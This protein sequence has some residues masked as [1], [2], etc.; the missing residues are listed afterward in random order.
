MIKAKKPTPTNGEL[1]LKCGIIRKS[2][3]A[4]LI[5]KEKWFTTDSD[6]YTAQLKRN[7]PSKYEYVE[8]ALWSWGQSVR[9]VDYKFKKKYNLRAYTKHG[10]A[11][12]APST[13]LLCKKMDSAH[14]LAM[15]ALAGKKKNKECVKK[16]RA[17]LL[18]KLQKK[19][20]PSLQ[21]GSDKEEEKEVKKRVSIEEACGGAE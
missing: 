6:K 7:R 15:G 9:R 17:I 2:V 20:S 11:R 12:S 14:T 19:T 21:I 8:H 1:A 5:A 10:K 3:S 18:W 13:K 16:Y 4:I